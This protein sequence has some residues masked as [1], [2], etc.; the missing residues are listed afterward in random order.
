MNAS[1]DSGENG[2]TILRIKYPSERKPQAHPI[3]VINNKLFLD[4]YCRSYIEDDEVENYSYEDKRKFDII[5][6]LICT[7]IGDE[8]LMDIKPSKQGSLSKTWQ[9]IG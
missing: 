5:A 3:G 6:A 1:L 4:F 8:A 9:D 7:E 2:E